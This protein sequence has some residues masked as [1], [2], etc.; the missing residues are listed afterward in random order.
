MIDFSSL[1]L[2]SGRLPEAVEFYRA[3]GVPLE[4]E[5]HDDG[6]EHAAADVGGVHIAI[7]EAPEM[8]GRA[9]RW[10]SSGSSFPGFY[11]ESLD[12]VAQALAGATMLA[13]HEVKPWGCR[14]VL[15]D[16]DGRPVEI[17]QRGHCPG[18]ER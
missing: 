9:P 16:P 11:V 18:P 15:Q 4:E 14:I 6:P 3:I 10:R 7:W 13:A 8:D 17:N 5:R 12:A 2:F 1:V